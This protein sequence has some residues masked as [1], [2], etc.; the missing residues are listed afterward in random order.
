MTVAWEKTYDSDYPAA[1]YTAKCALKLVGSSAATIITATESGE[2]FTFT[3]TATNSASLTVGKYEWV[4]YV[5]KGSGASTERYEMAR[6]TTEVRR[7]LAADGTVDSRSTAKIIFDAIEAVIQGRAAKDQ[8][9]YQIAGRRLDRTP[10]PDLIKLRQFYAGEVEKEN[11]ANA[12]A[13]GEAPSG[14]IRVRF[15]GAHTR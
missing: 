5:E 2:T 8:M 14:K 6:G 3:I 12:I 15:T 1:D 10:I 4:E 13:S 9:S 11:Q 7:Y